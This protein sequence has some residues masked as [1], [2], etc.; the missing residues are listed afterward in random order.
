[1]NFLGQPYYTLAGAGGG[2]GGSPGDVVGPSSSTV[3][4]VAR[5]AGIDGKT[6]KNSG[7]TV[8]DNGMISGVVSIQTDFV[9]STG[10]L[11][12]EGASTV[13]VRAPG[14]YI[15]V[16]EDVV[17]DSDDV[18]S[19][20][21]RAAPYAISLGGNTV[22]TGN[23]DIT[24][25]ITMNGFSQIKGV[26]LPSLPSDAATKEYVDSRNKGWGQMLY[27]SA[28]NTPLVT[29][30]QLSTTTFNRLMP[31]IDPVPSNYF[32]TTSTTVSVQDNVG[33]VLQVPGNYKLRYRVG[34]LST[35]ASQIATLALRINNVI[36]PA[37]E[38]YV[39]VDNVAVKYYEF[40][41]IFTTTATFETVYIF[42]KVATTTATA[43][44][45]SYLCFNVISF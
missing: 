43:I 5:F 40:E 24:G 42:A 19:L 34:L 10:S 27:N 8:S 28:T 33:F 11:A 32:I 17:I 12:V 39:V 4:A 21:G 13:E 26:A 30:G 29:S 31:I 22:L 45:T 36:A 1:M 20:T 2:T 9:S 14:S 35:A 3:N 38:Q 7:V 25:Q 16:R 23:F 44:Q 6:I 37:S 18:V 41:Y 15:L